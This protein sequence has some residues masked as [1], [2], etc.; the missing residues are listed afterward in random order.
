MYYFCLNSVLNIINT[1]TVTKIVSSNVTIKMLKISCK[2]SWA[3]FCIFCFWFINYTPA[4]FCVKYKGDYLNK[5]GPKTEDK[6]R[7]WTRH[8]VYGL[9]W[10]HSTFIIL[11]KVMIL[12]TTHLMSMSCKKQIV[13][14]RTKWF[15]HC[16]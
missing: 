7:P 16:A 11:W 9:V 4:S 8:P 3:L 13:P 10:Y 5:S 2:A 1:S 15:R 14:Q 6:Y 12:I